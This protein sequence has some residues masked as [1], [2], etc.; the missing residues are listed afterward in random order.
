MSSGEFVFYSAAWN[1][2]LFHDAMLISSQQVIAAIQSSS[3][4]LSLAA[5]LI[6]CET[7]GVLGAHPENGNV[8]SKRTKILS[9]SEIVVQNLVGDR[10]EVNE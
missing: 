2:S 4:S 7:K 1:L 6:L 3:L 10:S 9:L 5:S 8:N